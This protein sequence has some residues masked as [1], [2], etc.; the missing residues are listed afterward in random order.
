MH[1]SHA[2]TIWERFPQLVPGVMLVEQIHPEVAL[3]D[4]L[5]PLFA[6]ARARLADKSES[7]LPEVAA[8]RRAYSQMGMKPTQYRS[9]GEALLRRFRRENSLPRLHPLVD[10]CNAVSLVFALPI[11]VFDLDGVA[12]WLEVRPALGTEQ[13]LAFNGEIEHPE[14]NEVIFADAAGHAHA[15]RW[16]FRQSRRSTVSAS[17]RRVL[18]VSEALHASAAD[19]IPRLLDTLTEHISALWAAPRDQTVLTASQPRWVTP[20]S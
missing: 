7:E 18:I 11:A 14:P 5:E 20:T 10:L 6:Q 4:R 13:H 1:F 15:R 17:T 8:W 16:T 2:A 9:A 12:D 19:D 3:E